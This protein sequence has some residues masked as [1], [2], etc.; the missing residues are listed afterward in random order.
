[1]KGNHPP[2]AIRPYGK[3]ISLQCTEFARGCHP[4]ICCA[5]FPPTDEG[6]TPIQAVL[7]GA[8]SKCDRF[9]TPA[10]RRVRSRVADYSIRR[11]AILI[12]GRADA[13]PAERLDH[14][15]EATGR[16]LGEHEHMFAPGYDRF[17]SRESAVRNDTRRRP[18]P[19]SANHPYPTAILTTQRPVGMFSAAVIAPASTRHKLGIDLR[20]SSFGKHQATL[21]QRP[22]RVPRVLEPP[23]N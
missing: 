1:M 5:A 18:R 2:P 22:G 19:T 15:A 10:P 23:L 17:G 14:S 7:G 3:V 20:N 4:Q 13:K 16:D 11:R 6:R 8:G 9:D 21:E 12:R